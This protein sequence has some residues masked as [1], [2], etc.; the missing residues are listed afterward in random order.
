MDYVLLKVFD[1]GMLKSRSFDPLHD[2][3]SFLRS[4]SSLSICRSNISLSMDISL[5]FLSISFTFNL[6][7]AI[8]DR[9]CLYSLI[10]PSL[11]G[12]LFED[13]L[14]IEF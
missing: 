3:G 8:A 2:L 12:S 4:L 11:C 9:C 14:K 1:F 5:T 6:S 10:V 7:L 13:S